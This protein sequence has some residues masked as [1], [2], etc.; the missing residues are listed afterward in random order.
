MEEEF[1]DASASQESNPIQELTAENEELRQQVAEQALLIR[2]Y[3][4][5][6]QKIA[7][8][9]EELKD[10]IKRL[11]KE[12]TKTK[13]KLGEKTESKLEQILYAIRDTSDTYIKLKN[14]NSRILIMQALFSYVEPKG[15]SGKSP[16]LKKTWKEFVKPYKDQMPELNDREEKK[17]SE[18][19][20]EIVER[21]K[22]LKFFLP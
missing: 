4:G 5:N 18:S 20:Y 1:T 10:N 11:E 8:F 22:K 3:E 15:I 6:I 17:K 2:Q 21:A 14:M 12:L 7:D 13:V 16:F 19:K 9:A